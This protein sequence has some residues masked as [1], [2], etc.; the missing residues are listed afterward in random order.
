MKVNFYLIEYALDAI[1]RQKS[2][3]FFIFSVLGLIIFLLSSVFFVRNSLEYELHNSVSSMPQI[4]VQQ[5]VGGRLVSVDET[6]GDLFFSIEG[7]EN[8]VGRVWGYHEFYPARTH[9]AVVGIDEFEKIP[10]EDFA[11]D[12]QKVKPH[13]M[14]IGQSVAKVLHKYYYDDYFNFLLQ[15]GKVYKMDIIGKLSNDTALWSHDVMLMSKD[16]AKKVLGI[17]EDKVV[18]FAVFVSNEREIPTIASKIKTLLPGAKITTKK[19]L[20]AGYTS[21]LSYRGGF[22]LALFLVTL[23]TFFVIVYDKV[24]GVTS[25]EKNEVGILKAI[26]WRVEEILLF[27]FY[28]ALIISLFAFIIGVIGA[29]VYVYIFHAPLI[30]DIFVGASSLKVDMVLPFIF[31]IQ[32][33]L[34]IF[35]ASVPV[36]IAAIIIPTWKVA[37]LDV[38]ELIR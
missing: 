20:D 3:N 6:I 2:R 32:T 37:T 5:Q 24:S 13:S 17:A 11:K 21:L 18:D 22:F 10:Q 19:D 33:L 38:D 9:F 1:F 4:I 27:K 14:L 36:Y 28:E 15:D 12:I 35:F 16:D 30:R 8:V 25:Q 26:G 31:D 29:F 7:V 23:V 34:L